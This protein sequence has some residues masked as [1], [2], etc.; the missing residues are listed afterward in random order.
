MVS[1]GFLYSLEECKQG[2]VCDF[3][4]LY[5]HLIDDFVIQYCQRLRKRDFR[6]KAESLS[7]KK[8]GKR[9]YLSDA[10]I[11]GLMMVLN[12]YFESMVE[13]P[14]ISVSGQETDYRDLDK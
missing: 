8:L 7:R 9:E 1:L 5:K 3:E 13:I 4:E 10:D 6:V 14:R 2:L 12:Q 11:A